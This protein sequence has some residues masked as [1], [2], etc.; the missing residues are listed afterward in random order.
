M[1]SIDDIYKL[2]I[3]Q[4]DVLVKGKIDDIMKGLELEGESSDGDGDD[5]K[6]KNSK[7]G[8]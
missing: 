2:A 5:D 4:T 7:R 1:K 8:Q 6:G 3:K